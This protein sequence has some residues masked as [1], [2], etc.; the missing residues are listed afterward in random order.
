MGFT[1][2]FGDAP[3]RDADPVVGWDEF[4]TGVLGDQTLRMEVRDGLLATADAGPLIV[5]PE[6]LVVAAETAVPIKQLTVNGTSREIDAEQD[7]GIG[8]M[9]IGPEALS[10]VCAISVCR[11]DEAAPGNCDDVKV[12]KIVTSGPRALW[13][14]APPRLD[15]KPTLPGLVTGLRIT[16]EGAEGHLTNAHPV[17]GTNPADGPAWQ[18]KDP[19]AGPEARAYDGDA[20]DVI[21]RTLSD[22]AVAAVR[23]RIVAAGLGD[24]FVLDVSGDLLLRAEPVLEGLAGDG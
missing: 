16:P 20:R 7:F 5:D 8:P 17:G 24:D 22:P 14:A 6:R 1:I 12:E 11:V 19:L 10:S 21:A 13:D 2:E 4:R 15:A 23:A 18:H 3:E 9:Q